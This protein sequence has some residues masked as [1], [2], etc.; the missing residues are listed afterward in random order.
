MSVMFDEPRFLK[1]D[2]LS[3]SWI[4]D[5]AL[6]NGRAIPISAIMG[7][8]NRIGLLKTVLQG[9][10]GM[11]KHGN[12]LVKQEDISDIYEGYIANAGDLTDLQ[13]TLQEI[14]E[15]ATKNPMKL[16]EEKKKAKAKLEDPG[17]KK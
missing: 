15:M 16:A 5:N 8:L 13:K 3:M 14:Y 2:L 4:E 9:S 10:L 1:L 12:P 11:D 17:G 7:S 6:G